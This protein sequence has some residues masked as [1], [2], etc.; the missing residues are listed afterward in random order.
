MPSQNNNNTTAQRR[1]HSQS[2]GNIHMPNYTGYS[3]VQSAEQAKMPIHGF[4]NSASHSHLNGQYK[5]TQTPAER[6]TPPLSAGANTTSFNLDKSPKSVEDDR[7]ASISSYHDIHA[8]DI[9]RTSKFFRV[10][11]IGGAFAGIRAAQELEQLIPPHMITITVIERRDQYFYN[12][13][14]LRSMV[15]PELIDYVWLPYDNIF[16]YPHNRVIKGEVTGVYPN[17][18]I[19]KDGQKMDF[20]TLLVST[21]SVY[22]PPCKYETTSHVQGKAEMRIYA[23]IV[24][25]ADSILIIGGG[26]TGVGLAAEIATEYP[27]KTIILVHAGSRLLPS[28]NNSSSMSRKVH[29]KLKSLGVKVFLNERVIIPDEE[30]LT[31][32][33]EARWLKTS[34][35]RMLFSNYQVLC[36]GITFNTSFMDTLD[37]VFKHKIIDNKS[38]QIKV[39]P[40][41]QLCHPE[42][43]WIF[44]AGD[45]CNSPG[46][47]QAYRADSQ[48]AHV[49]RCMARMAQS[50]SHGNPK[51]FDVPLKPW[52]DPA[53]FMSVAMGPKAGITETPW[54]VL[55]DLPTRIMKSRE[56]FLQR[57]Y[58]EFNLEFP[59]IP[60]SV[61]TTGHSNNNSSTTIH[62]LASQHAELTRPQQQTSVFPRGGGNRINRHNV[63]QRI[64]VRG[65]V[66]TNLDPTSYD[67]SRAM[68]KAAISAA[69][70]LDHQFENDRVSLS[71]PVINK[72][73]AGEEAFPYA[74]FYARHRHQSVSNSEN[75]SEGYS[76][77]DDAGI[78][79]IT[80]H[81]ING[82]YL[83]DAPPGNALV[84]STVSDGSSHTYTQHLPKKLVRNTN[85]TPP[86]PVSPSNVSVS[87]ATSDA[88]SSGSSRAL[89]YANSMMNGPIL[90]R[91]NIKDREQRS[92]AFGSR[93]MFRPQ[94]AISEETGVDDEREA[95][96]TVYQG[97][98]QDPP[99]RR[100][101]PLIPIIPRMSS[102][103]SQSS[104]K[105]SVSNLTINLE[106]F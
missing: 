29:R 14:A 31:Y 92:N 55:G 62:Q 70:N 12:L 20:D 68:A 10:I 47:K 61:S 36:N 74:D 52:S 84:G 99:K 71:R 64:Y 40:T 46:E 21:G 79:S 49:A 16:R 67:L 35:G 65:G 66:A 7:H 38:G 11:I 28:E 105:R 33:I 1:L 101:K 93:T 6:L 5:N 53:Q 63:E 76:S 78:A 102:V 86:E 94:D 9:A 54:I 57:R 41:M 85:I 44:S 34:K 51:W 60:K 104:P 59:G 97:S 42:L 103:Q 73:M 15:K 19:L 26:P 98:L 24:R 82:G 25:A 43:P 17:A 91:C 13:G 23:E 45:V 87:T 88:S 37:P 27:N 50:W 56:L 81:V 32:R 48:G 58:K 22:P 80:N 106:Q 8:M 77:D 3:L 2:Y 72:A 89:S 90:P 30:P 39:L 95:R 69:D 100:H 83:T 75:I 18:V 4:Q 96:G